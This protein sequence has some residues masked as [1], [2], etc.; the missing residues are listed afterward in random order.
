MAAEPEEAA[1]APDPVKIAQ[2]KA[3]GE[4]VVQRR[5]EIAQEQVFAEALIDGA[6]ADAAAAGEDGSS[7][8]VDAAFAAQALEFEAPPGAVERVGESRAPRMVGGYWSSL[9]DMRE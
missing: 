5:V 8:E 1:A 9:G 2:L 4:A 6:L 7:N 3:D